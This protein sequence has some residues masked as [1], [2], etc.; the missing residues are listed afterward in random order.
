MNLAIQL[1]GIGCAFFVVFALIGKTAVLVVSSID[2]IGKQYRIPE[3]LLGFV[4][5][6]LAT[7]TPELFIGIQSSLTGIGQLSVGNILGGIVLLLSLIAGI[8]SVVNGGIELKGLISR[9][10]LLGVTFIF[11]TPLFLLLD[12]HLSRIDGGMLMAFYLFAVFLLAYESYRE[13]DAS[14]VQKVW[15]VLIRRSVEPVPPDREA[16]EK[17]EE[18]KGLGYTYFLLGVGIVGL[19]ILSR[20]A[21]ELGLYTTQLFG[22]GAFVVGFLIFALGT[23]LPELTIALTSHKMKH[24]ALSLGNIVGSA[25][26]NIFVLG[27]VGVIRPIQFAAIDNLRAGMLFLVIAVTLF[28]FFSAT[29]G[30]ITRREGVVLIVLNVIFVAIQIFLSP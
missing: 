30:R 2:R 15:S 4:I 19:L 26:A 14:L 24:E 11:F 29:G 18:E 5:L 12:S 9:P 25:V 10:I 7:S 6:G 1:I 13:R 17:K 3:F 27:F 28:F 8:V 21:L 16:I 23:N 22:F 20:I